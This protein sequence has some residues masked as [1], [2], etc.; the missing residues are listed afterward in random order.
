MK[1]LLP[2]ILMSLLI[3]LG[4]ATMLPAQTVISVAAGTDGIA[5]ALATAVDGD[6]IELTTSGGEYLESAT[7]TIVVKLTIRAKAGLA[8]KP[9]IKGGAAGTGDVFVINK[10]GLTVK[11][12]KFVGGQYVLKGQTTEAAGNPPD[13]SIKVDDC[14]FHNYEQRAIY[15]NSSCVYPF[16]SILVKNSIFKDGVKQGLYLKA[17]RNDSNI[18]PGSYRYCKI[19]NCLFVGLSSSSDGYPTYLEPGNRDVADKGWPTVIIDHST[20]DS[21]VYGFYTYTTPGALI[22]NCIVS[23]QTDPT[24]Y[25]YGIESGRFTGAPAST[26]KNSIYHKGSGV[27]PGNTFVASVIENVDSVKPLY[28]NPA[29]GDYSLLAGS[30]GKAAGTD[31]K[32]LGY[33][34]T[35]LP[36]DVRPAKISLAPKIYPNPTLG[37]L[38]ISLDEDITGA[39]TLE[40]FDVTGKVV[41]KVRDLNGQRIV[42]I[43]LSSSPAGMYYGIVKDANKTRTFKV[44]KK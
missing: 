16:D 42:E 1:K 27:H 4:L 23:N 2:K 21:C 25:C 30:P 40:I 20:A 32:D 11:G 13:V 22:Q 9:V 39:S 6:I 12:V 10:G 35:T 8:A 34:P 29:I 41:S 31:G 7:L 19:S 17:T 15:T 38:R 43:D 44:I 37:P 18:F 3:C 5:G 14:E 28:T 26:V 33:M 36:T 24:R